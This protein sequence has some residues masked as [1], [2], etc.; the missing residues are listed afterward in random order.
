MTFTH[1]QCGEKGNKEGYN[2]ITFSSQ[3][4]NRTRHPMEGEIITSKLSPFSK[5]FL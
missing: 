4:G 2:W 3:G 1:Q 5:Y